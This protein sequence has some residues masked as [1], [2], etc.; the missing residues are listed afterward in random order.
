MEFGTARIPQCSNFWP[1]WFGTSELWF[2]Q[3][4]EICLVVWNI[5]ITVFFPYIIYNYPP[6]DIRGA[7]KLWGVEMI[8]GWESQKFTHV[9]AKDCF[10]PKDWIPSRTSSNFHQQKRRQ[11]IQD[12]DPT[13]TIC[14][15]F[16]WHFLDWNIWIIFPYIGT[17]HPNWFHFFPLELLPVFCPKKQ[18]RDEARTSTCASRCQNRA[19]IPIGKVECDKVRNINGGVNGC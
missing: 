5:W 19:K 10:F 18:P 8:G 14:W 17:N 6:K 9:W 7:Q 13:P 3:T 1:Y 4:I 12:G 16:S 11:M 15:T 2:V